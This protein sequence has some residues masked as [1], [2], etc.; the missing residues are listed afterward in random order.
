MTTLF[1]AR[2][3]YTCSPANPFRMPE[4]RP[5]LL[6]H[7]ASAVAFALLLASWVVVYVTIVPADPIPAHH[8]HSAQVQQRQD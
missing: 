6:D 8:I 5:A 1:R 3:S 4:P 2:R 7:A